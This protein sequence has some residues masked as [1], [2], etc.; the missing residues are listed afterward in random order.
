MPTNQNEKLRSLTR[1]ALSLFLLAQILALLELLIVPAT[2]ALFRFRES[3]NFLSE[4]GLLI[5]TLNSTSAWLNFYSFSISAI[6]IFIL[7]HIPGTFLIHKNQTSLNYIA[8]S[9][10]LLFSFS[11]F[12]FQALSSPV[13]SIRKILFEI[14]LASAFIL[15]LATLWLLRKNAQHA[16]LVLISASIF[17]LVNLARAILILYKIQLGTL[18]IFLICISAIILIILSIWLG[19][20]IEQTRSS[21]FSTLK[22]LFAISIIAF[23]IWVLILPAL[24]WAK[25]YFHKTQDPKPPNVI[26]IV[27]DTARADHLSLYGYHRKTTPFLE[28]L[29]QYSLVFEKAFST[30]PWTLP[31]HASF[32]TGLLPSEHNCTYENLHLDS[33][34][35]TLAEMLKQRGYLTIGWS[36]NPLLNSASGLTQGFDKFVENN[37]LPIYSA[38][39]IRRAYLNRFPQLVSDNGAKLTNRTLFRWLNRLS[40]NRKP[41]FIFLNYMEPHTPYTRDSLAYTFFKKPE[42]ARKNYVSP[43]WDLYNCENQQNKN[44]KNNAEK[45]YDGSILYLDNELRKVFEFLKQKGLIHNT[46]IIILSDHGENFGE[47]NWWGHGVNLYNSD[48]YVPLLIF[49]P[50]ILS[51]TKISNN[52]SLKNLP[53]LLLNLLQN[54]NEKELFEQITKPEPIFAEVM[55]P[56]MYLDRMSQVC[57]QTDFSRLNRAK[58]ALLLDDYKLIWDSRNYWELYNLIQDPLELNNLITQNPELFKNLQ[59]QLNDFLSKHPYSPTAGK[60]N[61]RTLNAL[62]S[63]GYLK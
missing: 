15:W 20:K 47:H 2:Y 58:K 36:N 55:T 6:I 46:I 40:A 1:S 28:H 48:L 43:N 37:Q 11:V 60:I 10:I 61:S 41:F 63:L 34:F 62:K 19:L 53:E 52:F 33:H 8:I 25:W 42:N 22:F 44:L 23:G 18:G 3:Q 56:V 31:S 30:S 39:I 24:P 38:E 12:F 32:F 49:Y 17:I 50:K 7:I 13:S 59:N 57:P 5:R 4:M 14:I 21:L 26:M 16:F 29:A 9:L 45:W 54:K 51:P 35:T 27:M